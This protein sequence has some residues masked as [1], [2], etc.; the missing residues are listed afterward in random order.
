[1]KTHIINEIYDRI[2]KILKN[3]QKYPYVT[4]GS[5]I[6]SSTTARRDINYYFD[7]YPPLLDI[8]ELGASLEHEGSDYQAEIIEQ[9]KY[10]MQQLRKMLPDI[11]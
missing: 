1:M 5:L 7:A 2:S 9:I 6:V 10:K 3:D 11:S 8:A 4:I